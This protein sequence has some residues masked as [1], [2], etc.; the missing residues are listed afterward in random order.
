MGMKFGDTFDSLAL[1][2]L[3]LESIS[4]KKRCNVSRLI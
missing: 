2:A 4:D 3:A 1:L